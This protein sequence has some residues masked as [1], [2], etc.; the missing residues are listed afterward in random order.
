MLKEIPAVPTSKKRAKLIAKL[1][2]PW[3][4]FKFDVLK[5][6]LCSVGSGKALMLSNY[7][8]KS[9]YSLNILSFLLL[10]FCLTN[11][12]IPLLQPLICLLNR[13]VK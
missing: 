10:L 2:I 6:Y 9:I 5:K 3:D 13:D 11:V 4:V 8:M 7:F 1:A 12:N